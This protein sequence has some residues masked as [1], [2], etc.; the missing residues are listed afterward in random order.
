MQD[1]PE[2]QQVDIV[3]AGDLPEAGNR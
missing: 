3:G 1:A 2:I